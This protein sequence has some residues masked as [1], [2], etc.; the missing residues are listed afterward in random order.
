MIAEK[1]P[2]KGNRL[3]KGIS[4]T[5]LHERPQMEQIVNHLNFGQETVRFPEREA[6]LIRNHPFMTQLDFFDMQEDQER[7]W[8][9]ET[10]QHEVVRVVE[11]TGLS[12]VEVSAAPPSQSPTPGPAPRQGQAPSVGSGAG[13]AVAVRCFNNRSRDNV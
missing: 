7:K 6:K 10:R 5:G 11:E 3:K 4:P 2:A 12:A 9:A 13:L 8:E 1:L